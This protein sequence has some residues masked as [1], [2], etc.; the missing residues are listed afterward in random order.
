M[1]ASGLLTT[2]ESRK[3]TFYVHG[4]RT[5]RKVVKGERTPRRKQGNHRKPTPVQVS[6]NQQAILA[7]TAQIQAI[8][9][10]QDDLL[11]RAEAMDDKIR[12]L[13]E[14]RGILLEQEQ[15]RT[16]KLRQIKNERRRMT[17]C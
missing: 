3:T 12:Q 9:K 14:L 1:V 15:E 6:T 17:A 8:A 2:V 16:Q 5:P 7:L 11:T 4:E 10:R 13:T